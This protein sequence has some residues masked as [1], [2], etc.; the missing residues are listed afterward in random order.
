MD[1]TGLDAGHL[2]VFPPLLEKGFA[3]GGAGKTLKEF[4]I[5][6]QVDVMVDDD[7]RAAMRPFKEY[8]VTWSLIH[9]HTW[10]PA[11][12]GLADRFAGLIEA[13]KGHDAEAR[14]QAG[15]NLLEGSFAK[16]PCEC[17]RYQGRPEYI[18]TTKAA[19]SP[20]T[21]SPACCARRDSISMDGCG[22]LPTTSSLNDCGAASSM[23]KSTSR[24]TRID[25]SA[26]RHRRLLRILGGHQRLHQAL[27]Y[28]TPRQ[29]FDEAHRL[30][31]R[32]GEKNP[33]ASTAL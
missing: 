29:V 22:R 17:K 11:V 10:T 24:R 21:I 18:D 7:V 19:S 14:V 16:R 20:T 30:P 2:P 1:A 9:R 8:V 6:S 32:R 33:G 15:G 31:T 13:G 12:S 4:K 25:S 5:W 28:R 23:R 3:R 27:G 26:P